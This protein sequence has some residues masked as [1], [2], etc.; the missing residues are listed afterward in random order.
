MWHIPGGT[1]LFSEP[2]KHAIKRIADEEL[3]VRI[4]I[5]KPLG[6]I[7]YF[8]DNGRHT[9]CNAYLVEIVSGKLRGSKQ[10]KEIKFFPKILYRAAGDHC[11]HAL[12]CMLLS[13][14]V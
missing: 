7:E 1:I 3:G 5:V 11:I 4:N 13:R 10:G 9:V 8:V 2:V 12:V 6:L 14:E